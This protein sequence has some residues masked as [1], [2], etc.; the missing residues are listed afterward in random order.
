MYTMYKELEI[1]ETKERIGTGWLPPLPDLRDY[2][3]KR[4]TDQ[5][6]QYADG[7]LCGQHRPGQGVGKEQEQ[8][9]AQKRKS[10]QPAVIRADQMAQEGRF[11]AAAATHYDKNVIA[12]DRKIE[13]PL[14]DKVSVCHGQV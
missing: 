1:G 14:D 8:A 10:Y 6:G 7:H 5:R 4:A 11:P 2:T 12:V 3:E 9:S 13:I